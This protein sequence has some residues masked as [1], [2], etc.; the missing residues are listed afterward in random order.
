VG[1]FGASQDA[2]GALLDAFHKGEPTSEILERDDGFIDGVTAE[3]YLAPRAKWP[4]HEQ[5]AARLARGRVLDIGCG[6]GRV[7]MDLQS[8]GL[9]VTAIDVSPLAVRICKERGVRKARV[10][11]ITDIPPRLGCFDTIVMFGNN[12]GLFGTPGRARWLLRRFRR[13]T[14]ADARIIAAVCDPH[15]TKDPAH[16]AYHERNR[17]RGRLPGQLRVRV[18]YR[19]LATPWYDYLFVSKAELEDI[20]LGTG[21]VLAR[22]IQSGGPQYA[23]MLEKTATPT[24]AG[25]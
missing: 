13:C 23:V 5:Q 25:K 2:F 3:A 17:K 8:R 12:F 15:C 21:W 7:A 10:M 24:R 14:S 20:L 22:T 16:L 1:G 19:D 6:A 18:R 4:K 11:R 9:D